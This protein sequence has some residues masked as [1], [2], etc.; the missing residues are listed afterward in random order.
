MWI[1]IYFLSHK[2]VPVQE[3]SPSLICSL[4]MHWIK[5]KAAAKDAKDLQ[6]IRLELKEKRAV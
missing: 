5:F 2:L 3:L 4:L 1:K 6:M